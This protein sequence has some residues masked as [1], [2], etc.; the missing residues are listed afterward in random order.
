MRASLIAT[1]AGFHAE[2]LLKPLASLLGPRCGWSF[3]V[4]KILGTMRR[5]LGIGSN[6]PDMSAEPPPGAIALLGQRIDHL[7]SASSTVA[8]PFGTRRYAP[9]ERDPGRSARSLA[10]LPRQKDSLALSP[11]FR[12]HHATR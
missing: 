9:L 3:S 7:A 10:S 2:E 8:F 5:I 1:C 11:Q 12:S 4:C 6:T